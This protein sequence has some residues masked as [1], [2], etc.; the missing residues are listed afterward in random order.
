MPFT[1]RTVT[2]PA[3]AST[4]VFTPGYRLRGIVNIGTGLATITAVSPAVANQGW[5]LA[6]ASAAGDQGGGLSFDNGVR[7]AAPLY[8]ISTAGTT[9][10]VLED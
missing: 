4:Q 10:V 2:L 9:L 7:P 1:I 6:A 5:P 3:G 8:A